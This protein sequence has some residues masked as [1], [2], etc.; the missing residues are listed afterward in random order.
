MRQSPTQRLACVSATAW[1]VAILLC[2]CTPAH[3]EMKTWIG[4]SDVSWFTAT[5][6]NPEGVPTNG[7]DVVIDAVSSLTNVVLTGSTPALGQL[8][9]MNRALVFSNWNTVLTVSNMVVRSGGRLALPAAFNEVAGLSNRICVVCTNFVLDPGGQVLAD[10]RGYIGANG[11]NGYGP[12]KGL[13]G[14]A[15]VQQGSG[16]GHGGAGGS[17]NSALGGGVYGSSSAPV[18]PGSSGGGGWIG[19]GGSG[20]GAVRIDAAGTVTVNG[21]ISANGTAAGPGQNGGGGAGGSIYITC[22]TLD[23]TGGVIQASGGAPYSV[24]GGGGGGGRIA[25]IYTAFAGTPG[26]LR[27]YASGGPGYITDR[28]DPTASQMGT[29]YLS[30]TNPLADIWKTQIQ[31]AYLFVP[32]F[33]TWSAPVVVSNATIGLPEGFVL[34]GASVKVVTTNNGL[35]LGANQVVLNTD[36]ELTT[37]GWVLMGSNSSMNCSGNFTL[38][39]NAAIRIGSASSLSCTGAITVLDAAASILRMGSNSSLSCGG[40]ILI[41]RGQVNMDRNPTITCSSNLTLTNG[42]VLYVYGGPTNGGAITGGRI[43]VTNDIVI[44]PN[45]WIFPYSEPYNGGAVKFTLRRLLINTNAGIN[46]DGTGYPGGY[47]PARGTSG[48][49]GGGGGGHGG[50][51]GDGLAYGTRMAGGAPAYGLSN[52][53]VTSGSGGGNGWFGVGGRGGGV[54]H[55]DAA[56]TIMNNGVLSANGANSS[57]GY[58]GGGAGGSVYVI[59]S[60]LRG[61]NGVIRAK[62]GN[63]YAQSGNNAGG[64]GGGGRVSLWIGLTSA[65]RARAQAGDY[66]RMTITN[67]YTVFPGEIS[68]TNGSGYGTAGAGTIFVLQAY[69]ARGIVM[70]IR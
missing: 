68:A 35:S 62:G 1:L 52:A 29:L 69:P 49:M 7:D 36:F 61:T 3:G 30:N 66:A 28:T 13:Y 33:T 38:R 20:G 22:Q 44:G 12:G 19:V 4:S 47:G 60:E 43:S 53:P 65:Q 63:G 8:T 39:S 40:N 9:I 55:V 27:F 70:F 26:G 24:N 14:P 54:V 41:S 21:T 67:A 59:C 37:N 17:C 18:T 32:G 23:G 50:I 57:F 2:P 16:G 56:E 48:N 10:G 5:N 11:A 64:G 15:S 25:I 46:A 58:S 6:W 34:S 31:G 42:A 51:G 45:S